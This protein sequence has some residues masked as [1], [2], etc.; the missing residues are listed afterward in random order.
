MKV[1]VLEKVT[2]VIIITIKTAYTD[3]LSSDFGCDSIIVT[4]L[5]IYPEF[6]STLSQI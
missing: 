1:Y 2:L 3:T 6:Q 4:H 5:N